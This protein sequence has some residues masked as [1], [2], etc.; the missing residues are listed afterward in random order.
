MQTNENAVAVIGLSARLP[1]ARNVHEFWANLDAGRDSVRRLDDAELL[2]RGLVPALLADPSFVRA[3]SAPDG[4]DLFDAA[5]FGYSPREAELMDPQHRLFLECAVEALEDAG[6]APERFSG[7]IGVFG[8]APGLSTYLLYNLLGNP[9]VAAGLDP[10]QAAV[11]T[12]PDFLT[13]RVSYKLGLGGPSH[14]VQSACSS[15]LVAVHV[16]C[17]SLLNDECDLALA[18]GASIATHQLFGYRYVP[19]GLLSRGGRCRPFDADADGTVFG[20]GAGLVVLRRL[21]DAIADGDRVLAVIRGSAV[22][23]DGSLKAGFTAPSVEGQ[24]R[25]VAEALAY[26]GVSAETI[27]YVEAHGTGTPLGDPIEIRALTKAFRGFTRRSGYCAIGSVKSN[28][29]HLDAAAGVTGLIKTVL[30]L[31]HRVLPASLHFERPNPQ[32][33]FDETPFFVNARRAAWAPLEGV[34]RAGVSSFGFG[35]TNAHVIV[36]EAPAA[37]PRPADARPYHLVP[38]SA[39]SAGALEAATA[40][41][42]DFLAAGGPELRLGDVAFTVQTG[43]SARAHRRALVARGPR[44]AAEALRAPGR[45]AAGVHEGGERR[46]VWAFPGQGGQHAGMGAALHAHEPAF[47][48]A[49]DRCAARLAPEYGV[50]LRRAL[51]A[52]DDEARGWLEGTAL[53][54]PALFAVEYALSALWKSW[55]VSPVAVVGHSVGEYAAAVAAGV[56]ELDDALALVAARARL[57]ESLPRGAM[58]AVALGEGALAGR[59]PESVAIAAVNERDRCVV[60]G[61][62]EAIAA[63]EASLSSERVACRRLGAAHA[64][65]SPAVEPLVAEFRAL[66][67]ARPRR[68]PSLPIVSCVTGDWLEAEQAVDPAYWARHLREPVRF[69]AALERLASPDSVA[70]EAHLL[71]LGPGAALSAFARRL[72]T[73]AGRL[74]VASLPRADEGRDALEATLEAAARLWTG[75]VALD[76]AALGAGAKRRRLALPT[77]PFERHRYWI[78]GQGAPTARPALTALAATDAPGGPTADRA[79][80]EAAGLPTETE[81]AL[82]EQWRSLLG[83]ERVD[84]NDNFFELGGD[85]LLATQLLA[86]AAR[87]FGAGLSL[88]DVMAQPTLTALAALIDEVA[89]GA[90]DLVPVGAA[91]EPDPARR[92][93]PFPLTDMQQA[94]WVGRDMGGVATHSYYEIERPHFDVDRFGRAWRRLIERHDMLRAE[95]LPDGR[96]RIRKDVPPYEI[97]V[98]DLRDAPEGTAARELDALRSRMSH[99]IFR[100][101]VWPLFEVRATLLPGRTRMHIGIDGL[102]VDGWSAQVLLREWLALYEDPERPLEPLTLSFRDYVVAEVASRDGETYGRS[103]EYWRGRLPS[104]PPMP[105]L[106]L[107]GAP[108]TA[109]RFVRRSFRIEP[110]EWSRLRARATR[111]ELATAGLLVAAY[112][113]VLSRW[114]RQ[115]RFCVNVPRFNRLPLHPEVNE[116][117]GEFASFTLVEIDASEPLSFAEFARRVQAQLWRDLEHHHVSG[118]RV[119]RELSRA[120]GR[121]SPSHMPIVFTSLPR[122]RRSRTFG[123]EAGLSANEVVYSIAQT[124]QVWLDHQTFEELGALVSFWDALESVFPPG[125]LDDMFAA[126]RALLGALAASDEAWSRPF[127]AVS[128][129]TAAATATETKAPAP[130]PADTELPFE[131]ARLDHMI[132]AQAALGPER[133]AVVS[134]GKTLTYRELLARA[135]RLARELQ[136]RGVVADR[137]VGIVMEKGWEQVVAAVAVLLAGGAYLPLDAS[138]PR[139][140]TVR[141]L[142]RGEIACVLTQ[143]A[144]RASFEGDPWEALCVEDGP[145]PE[146]DDAPLEVSRGPDD[147]VYVI[148]TSGST[149]EP[150]GVMIGQRSLV[151]VV[152]QTNRAF[153]VGPSDRAL[154]LTPLHHDLS[155][156]DLFGLLAAG[157]ALVVPDAAERRDP[158]HWLALLREARVTIWNSVPAAME[159]LLAHAE[160]AGETLPDSLRLAI[161]GGDWVPL[162]VVPRLRAAAPGA[163]LVTIGGPTETTI[164][165]V[166]HPVEDL[167]PSW[168]SIPYG[169]P[170]PHAR[171]YVMS[172]ALEECPTWV[173]GEL[174]CAGVPLARGYWRDEAKTAERFVRHPRTGERLYRTGDYGRRWP[175]GTLEFLGRRDE[176]IKLRGHRVELGEIEAALGRAPAVRQA[177]VSLREDAPGERRLVA[178]VVPVRQ[179]HER[180]ADATTLAATER[181]WAGLLEGGRTAAA[182]ALAAHSP[183][184]FRR[185]MAALDRLTVAR[186]AATLK[187]W[188]AFARAGDRRS[189]SGIAADAGVVP[190]YRKLVGHWLEMLCED[191]LLVANGDGTFSAHD[192]L[193]E[194]DFEAL[195]AEARAAG[196]TIGPG[197]ALLERSAESL[198]AI[199][200]GRLA[201][202]DVFFPGGSWDQAQR[203]Y[204][205]A[206]Y[207]HDVTAEVVRRVAQAWPRDRPL[208]VLEIGAGTGGTSTYLFPVLPAERTTYAYTDVSSFFTQQAR[209]QFA[210]FPFLSFSTLDIERDPLAQGYEPHSF[211]LVVAAN[212]IHGVRD[213][214]ASLAHVRALLAPAGLF[215]LEEETRWARVFNISMGLLEGLT[216]YDEGEGPARSAPFMPP[217]RWREALARGGFE[218]FAAFPERDDRGSHVMVARGPRLARSSSRAPIDVTALRAHV[219]GELPE[220]MVPAAWVLLDALPLS[221]NGKVSRV[222]LPAPERDAGATG[223]PPHTPTEQALA[224]IWA[225]VLSL[226]AVGADDNFFDLG[227]DSI[228][229]LQIIARAKEIGF[230]LSPRQ[231]FDHQTLAALAAAIDAEGGA[232]RPSVALSP[233]QAAF[234]AFTPARAAEIRTFR[235]RGPLDLAR[236]ERAARVVVARDEAFHVG[237]GPAG[238]RPLD[239]GRRL[240]WQVQAP[241]AGAVVDGAEARRQLAALAASRLDRVAGPLVAIVAAAPRGAEAPAEIALALDPLIADEPSWGLLLARLTDAYERDEPSAPPTTTPSARALGEWVTAYASSAEAARETPA[242]AATLEHAPTTPAGGPTAEA[243]A[244]SV[245][246]TLAAPATAALLEALPRALRADASEAV[247]AA[248]LGA[249]AARAGDGPHLFALDDH[250]RPTYDGVELGQAIGRFTSTYPVSLHREGGLHEQLAAVKGRLRDVGNHG[251]GYLAYRAAAGTADAPKVDVS[252][253]FSFTPAAATCPLFAGPLEVFG[254]RAPGPASASLLVDARVLESGLELSFAYDES[255]HERGAVTAIAHATIKNL[256]A[257]AENHPASPAAM[258]SADVPMARLGADKFRKLADLLERLDNDEVP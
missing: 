211:D 17:Q 97:A 190:A 47:R 40:E 202:L 27:G 23:N 109:A 67:A 204:A 114:S 156:Y 253:R 199:V 191:G 61:P 151:N 257:L 258:S 221:A 248:L 33:A 41:L 196:G 16:A 210:A 157:G 200:T 177:V 2:A 112:A 160:G 256:R 48:E 207:I 161:L 125:V 245:H 99:Q 31:G 134:H 110:A 56:F 183:A 30:A 255:A 19:G 244:T 10:R 43:R 8:G 105:E 21:D 14:V 238:V 32:I 113:A 203:F 139:E 217:E 54:Q 29:G 106:P 181:A 189:A 136:A 169:K 93:E 25:V 162:T 137:L 121:A 59:L 168:K 216:R 193:P 22:N 155:A 133:V 78:E 197:L 24:A 239:E 15:S 158:A 42:A 101:D 174:C 70:R 89:A 219:R 242:W 194:F 213:L 205:A 115:P 254:K 104:L 227:G 107:A 192:A 36:E 55:G 152:V 218:D 122:D 224:A 185:A 154:A 226:P 186:V 187:G 143:P 57:V 38:L 62:P 51:D 234:V 3:A 71:E 128:T 129:A 85:S 236:L 96:Q 223:A 20:S 188:G 127:A 12:G 144:L 100:P 141:L 75:G 52:G 18:G 195:W 201:A 182:A 84:A 251:A 150:K 108:G 246:A 233:A 64:F 39:K 4:V 176:Q 222:D 184:E 138:S 208:R 86:W 6:H 130:P 77:Y 76:W 7:A 243:K 34:R 119:L 235:T 163:R 35:G 92:H 180:E 91:I 13:T 118:V 173:A 126:Y 111:A 149:G 214:D 120:Q 26:A 170:I 72:A 206:Q 166:W 98:L 232:P 153:G 209:Q 240:G 228:L 225:Q 249:L 44:D 95:V 94:Y 116:L 102:M 49:F 28:V 60:S 172:E 79:A 220:H 171:Y 241:A 140:R 165:N 87:R 215:V 68:R 252:V 175:D 124:S 83:L 142:A 131:H 5:Y 250:R 159:M 212:V 80:P 132:A 46:V 167:D 135:R 229:G 73:P 117:L 179:A 69:A 82:A 50:D 145:L 147:L 230:R 164:W 1:G 90:A 148:Y 146:G 11:A 58:L 65:H 74:A 63:L 37:A 178:Y 231:L 88:R 53:G 81:R 237:Y 247:L 103:L 123:G 9:D 45:L 198:D 66:V